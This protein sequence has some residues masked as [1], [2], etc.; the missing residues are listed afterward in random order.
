LE[1]FSNSSVSM[2]L[3][4]DNPVI[5]EGRAFGVQTLSGTGSLRVGAELLNKHLKYTNFYYSSPT[6]G[7]Y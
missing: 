3:G 2:L 4:E 6:W 5:T 7:Q 1:N